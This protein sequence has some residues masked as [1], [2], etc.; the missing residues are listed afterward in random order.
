MYIILVV[1]VLIVSRVDASRLQISSIF[2][3]VQ[4]K[5]TL[6]IEIESFP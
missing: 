2:L 3:K 6:L 5:K 4:I 1:T